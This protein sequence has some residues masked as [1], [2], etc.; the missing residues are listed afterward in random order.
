[1]EAH[2]VQIKANKLEKEEQE[3]H[4]KTNSQKTKSSINQLKLKQ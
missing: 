3:K 1:M 4:R 2:K